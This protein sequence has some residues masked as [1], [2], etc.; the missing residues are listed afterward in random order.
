MSRK[1]D[2]DI[3]EWAADLMN[4]IHKCGF[5]GINAVERILRDPGRSTKGSNHFVHWWPKNRRIS[6]ISKAMHQIDK[7]SQICLIVSAG[8]IMKETE[9]GKT[10]FTEKDLKNKS[11]LT[12]EEI[13]ERVTVSKRRLAEILRRNR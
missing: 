11:S 13:R 4:N 10:V 6:R 8:C 5:S 9:K 12:V 2:K 3:E 1:L 7:I